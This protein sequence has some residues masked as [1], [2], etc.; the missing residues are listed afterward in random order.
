M[1]KDSGPFLSDIL[2]FG[3]QPAG[4]KEN[5]VKNSGLD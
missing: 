4:Q 1:L 5:V 3:A 2:A